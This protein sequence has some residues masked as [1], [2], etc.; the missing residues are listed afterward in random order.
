MDFV[1]IRDLENVIKEFKNNKNNQV[2][3]LNDIFYK[4]NQDVIDELSK[5]YNVEFFSTPNIEKDINCILVDRKFFES[6]F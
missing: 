6:M 2:I 3:V 4:N 5:E 1:I